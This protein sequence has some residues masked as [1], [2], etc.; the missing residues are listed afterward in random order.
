M[1][2]LNLLK[3][4]LSFFTRPSAKI[5]LGIL[6]TGGFAAGVFFW[7]AFEKGLEV[8]NSEEFCLSCHTMKDNLLPELQKTI[9]W[10]NRTG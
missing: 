2:I 1:F 9:H 3:K 10:R 6:V 7:M 5:G 8:T 4:I